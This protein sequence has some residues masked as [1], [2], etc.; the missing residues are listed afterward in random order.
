MAGIYLHIPFCK[1]KCSYCNF[2]FS[3]DLKLK[4]QMVNAICSELELRK[5]EILGPVET[6]Y[7]GG[8]TP[9]LLD[10]NEINQIFESIFKNY[11]VISNPE[12]TLEANP[13]DLT[14]EKIKELKSTP[15]NRFSIGIQSFF[16]EDL[17]LM[18]R[19]H[20]ANEAIFSVKTA[21]DFGFENI[22]IDLIYG[23]PSTTDE[24]WQKNLEIALELKVLHISS[25]A[26]T[27]EPKT[28]LDY[29]I[30]TKKIPE[31]DE[32]KQARQFQILVDTLTTNDFIHYE[33]SNFG[34]EGF[35]S[36]HNSNYWKG[37]TY[38]GIGPS[39]HSYDGKNRSW[40]IPNNSV[41]L[42]EI[43]QNR[44]PNEVEVLNENDRFNELIMI[45]LRMK[46][47]LNS[48]EIKSKFPQEFYEDF[49][50]EIRIHLDN[51]TVYLEDRNFRLTEKGKFLADG[52]ASSLFRVD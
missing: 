15:I 17:R 37:K 27:V 47:G 34:K 32:E 10:L 29:Q 24:I 19:A 43:A 12:V 21:Q 51:E 18:N 16:D 8:G 4:S 9:S 23:S 28:V 35:L 2:H 38:L 36:Q 26:L 50:S 49:L 14:Y 42:K 7:F 52:I 22:T 6:I 20:N 11:S 45:R 39:A 40:N 48:E 31:I 1:Q 46:E 25:Y 13:D 3:T 44:L 33:I 30:Q 5:S 41:Y